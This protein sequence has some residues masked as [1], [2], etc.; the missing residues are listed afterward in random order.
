[1]RL[2]LLYSVAGLVGIANAQ[3]L[4]TQIR[5]LE[6]RGNSRAARDLLAEA[7]R[8]APNDPVSLSFHAEFLDRHGDPAARDA[9]AKLLG[10]LERSGGDRKQTARRLVILD[11]LHG[12]RSAAT[13]HLAVYRNAGGQDFSATIPQPQP[14][15][16]GQEWSTIDI[17]GPLRS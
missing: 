8:N 10:V 2:L 4:A 16:A 12:D 6:A 3:N 13:R 14:R 5:D 1:M 9:Y 17:P 7:V 11:L 15:T